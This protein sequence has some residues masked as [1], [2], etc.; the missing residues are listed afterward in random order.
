MK[1][2]TTMK[3]ILLLIGVLVSLTAAHFAFGQEGS[4]VYENKV[5]LHRTLPKERADMKNMIPEFRTSSDQLFFTANESL[6]KPVVEDEDDEQDAGNGGM[7]MRIQRPMN[8]TY[9][10]QGNMKR[11]VLQEFM[12]KKYLI[13]DTLK[14]MPWKLGSETKEVKGYACKQ[15]TYY[16]EER[17]QNV[18]A[19]YTDK[20]R[21]FLGPE[22]FNTLPG[23]VLE[24]NI[25]D[26]ERVISVKTIE[27]RP[28]KKNELSIPSG[29]T[30]TTET[31]FR[32]M[33][34]EQMERMRANG[35][36]IIRN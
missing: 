1:I 20:L 12:G 19:W 14:T 18:T 8:E 24:V 27:L 21:P 28:L 22:M 11:V 9:V 5:N 36:I 2:S 16:N 6:Y 34:S 32:K 10:D 25:N 26:G 7:V 29:G 31:A 13:E 4:I 17:K 23:T 3:R 35:G 30:K 15:A 33:V